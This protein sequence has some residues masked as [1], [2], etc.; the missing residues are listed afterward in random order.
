MS[1]HLL[2]LRQLRCLILLGQNR[3]TLDTF[4]PNQEEIV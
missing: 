3:N 4:K 1:I 2:S